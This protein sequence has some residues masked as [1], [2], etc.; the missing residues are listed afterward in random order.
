MVEAQQCNELEL[1]V[2]R[3]AS[4]EPRRDEMEA[5]RA[6]ERYSSPRNVTGRRWSD[7]MRPIG[8]SRGTLVPLAPEVAACGSLPAD[9]LDCAD[10]GVERFGRWFVA[11]S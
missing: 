9:D 1:R 11:W 2:G 3:P 5:T 10:G 8:A 6:G 7:A 4:V